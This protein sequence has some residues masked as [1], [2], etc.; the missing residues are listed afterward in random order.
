MLLIVAT[1]RA[2]RSHDLRVF[3]HWHK[4]TTD[5]FRRLF[6]INFE[7]SMSCARYDVIGLEKETFLLGLTLT[8]LL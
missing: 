7:S 5:E 2:W 6:H 8:L 4:R 1:A 3:R